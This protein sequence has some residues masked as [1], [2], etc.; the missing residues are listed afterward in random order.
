MLRFVRA[1]SGVLL[2]IESQRLG[3]MPFSMHHF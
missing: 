1:V 2:M 3:S